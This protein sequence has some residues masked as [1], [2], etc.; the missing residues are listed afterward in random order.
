CE[1][2]EALADSTYLDGCG[3]DLRFR[4]DLAPVQRGLIAAGVIAEDDL[5]ARLD[6][7]VTEGR[8]NGEVVLALDEVAPTACTAAS[9]PAGFR[10]ALGADDL[11]A[12]PGL[13]AEPARQVDAAVRK[14][15]AADQRTALAGARD[16]VLAW[17]RTH[18]AEACRDEG[19]DPADPV[20][21]ERCAAA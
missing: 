10:R 9:L 14:I 11:A 15:L 4:P 18:A 21:L 3:A 6:G 5:L 19:H 2:A 12:L 1:G 16:E 20:A 7:L 8:R 13:A 17:V